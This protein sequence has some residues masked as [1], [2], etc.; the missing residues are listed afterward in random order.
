M[1]NVLNS[2][3]KPAGKRSYDMPE[4]ELFKRAGEGD[5][6]AIETIY[7]ETWAKVYRFVYFK[8][9]NRQEAEDITQ[10]AYVKAFV[11]QQSGDVCIEDYISY[12]KTVSMNLLRD[13]WRKSK[14]RAGD[15]SLDASD[16]ELAAVEDQTEASVTQTVISDALQRISDDQ[17]KVVVLR[18][19]KGYSVAETA[20]IMG[21]GEGAVRALQYRALCALAGILADGGV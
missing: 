2:V 17:R 5:L 21:K 6:K 1:T 16:R 7:S 20:T 18:I 10:E 4:D 15:H 19:I 9:Q 11:R 12:L 13:K 14:L 8:V 3:H